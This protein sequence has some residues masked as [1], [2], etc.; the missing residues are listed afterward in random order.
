MVKSLEGKTYE[1]KCWFV[2]PSQEETVVSYNF[3]TRGVKRQVLIS[4]L[5]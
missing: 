1:E 5:W 3:L 4:A 2:Q